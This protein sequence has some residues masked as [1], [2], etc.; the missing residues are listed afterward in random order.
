MAQ[1]YRPRYTDKRTGERKRSKTWHIRYYTPDGV[2]HHRK[3]FRDKRA[4]ETLAAE[5][6]RTGIHEAAGVIDPTHE[7]AKKPLAE[8]LVDYVAYLRAKGDTPRHVRQIETYA[9][10]CL[11]YCRFV[12]VGDVQPSAVLT[13]LAALRD[14]GKGITTANFYLTAAKG[15]TRWLWKD[16]RISSDPLAG[17]SKLANAASD[18]RRARRD[19]SPD[20][21]AWLSSET[22]ASGKS[23]RGLTGPDR[24]LL[25]LTAAGTGLRVSELAELKPHDFSLESDP[26]TVIVK[27]GYA[28][29]RQSA[30][31]PLAADLAGELANYLAGKPSRGPVWPGTW[32]DRAA[33]MLDRDLTTASGRKRSGPTSWPTS[34]PTADMPISMHCGTPTFHGSFN[35]AHRQKRRRRWPGIRRFS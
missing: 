17:V 34:M 21:I 9:R 31:Q 8:H 23:F 6:E 32:S 29:N 19:L 15:F 18:V 20:E 16:R 24:R 2:R 10:A 5:L 11:D 7:H 25:Y 3:G 12:R 1:I 33:K 22:L 35:Q 14:D 13:F 30:T 4:T 28:K 26:P 27:A